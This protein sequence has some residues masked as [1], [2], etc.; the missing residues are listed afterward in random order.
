MTPSKP[1]TLKQRTSSVDGRRDY[2]HQTLSSVIGLLK[3]RE[4]VITVDHFS[5][6]KR[7]LAWAM[8]NG[9]DLRDYMTQR[10]ASSMIFMSL[11][12]ST[13]LSVLFNSAK[14]TGEVRQA[15]LLEE[16]FSVEFWVGIFIIISAILTLF[17]LI[18]TFTA[19]TMVSAVSEANAH[20]I[21]RSSIGQYVAE[22]PGKFIVGAIYSFLV[23]LI[24][25]FF[26]LLPFGFW[27]VLLAILVIALFVQTIAAFSAFGRIIMHTGAMGEK[28]I[29]DVSYEASLSPHNL[30]NNLLTKAR[31]S[32]A[33]NTSI[34]RQYRSKA[35][36]IHRR[37]SEEEMS[38]HLS[39]RNIGY[40][41][42][43][44]VASNDETVVVPTRSRAGSLVRF[45][46]G[47]DTNGDRYP[48]EINSKGIA[49][50]TSTG[51]TFRNKQITVRDH[52]SPLSALSTDD[53]SFQRAQGQRG[54]F[55]GLDNTL[56]MTSIEESL[57]LSNHSDDLVA[58]M[59]LRSASQ[60]SFQASFNDERGVSI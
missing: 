45:S 55:S 4:F 10:Y 1:L 39:E 53:D 12:L 33:N 22:L 26:L 32:L 50:P 49:T 19:W 37:L 31:A 60:E 47:L 42:D 15:L 21:F 3:I 13:E 2:S 52:P 25:F 59:W 9:K 56:V 23:W 40:C 28:P 16:H 8:E 18:S 44:S 29:F 38:G 43:A 6:W 7:H 30:H 58:A 35:K 46:D 17:S 11:L 41:S 51:A 36:P 54:P 24:L 57:S 14:V 48:M 27:S 5:I 34:R 20:C